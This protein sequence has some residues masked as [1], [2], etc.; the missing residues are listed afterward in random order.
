MEKTPI[1][2]SAPEGKFKLS[3]IKESTTLPGIAVK[4]TETHIEVTYQNRFAIYDGDSKT[5]RPIVQEKVI[6]TDTRVPK[7]GV[8]LV[9]LGGNNGSTF[10]AG[11]LANRKQ[12]TWATKAGESSA[13]FYGSFTQS[14]TTHVGFKFNEDNGQLTDVFK[15]IKELLPMVNPVEF[16]I[17]GWDIS[18]ANLYESVKRAHVLEPTLIEQLKGDLENI[19]PMKAVLNPDFIAANQADRCDNVRTGTN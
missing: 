5:P 17:T 19:V 9:G 7:L 11:V 2:A 15:P 10:T 12:L 1:V 18:S 16:D 14:A 4:E 8:M 3:A 6:R 13:N